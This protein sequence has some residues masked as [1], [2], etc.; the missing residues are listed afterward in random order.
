MAQMHVIV[1]I[2][3]PVATATEGQSLFDQVA[4]LL[5]AISDIEVKGHVTEN[6]AITETPK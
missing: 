6:F 4:A 2:R 1:T 3:K 5:K